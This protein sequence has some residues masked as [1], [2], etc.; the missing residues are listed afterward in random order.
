MVE[1]LRL[2][3]M[4]VVTDVLTDVYSEETKRPQPLLV[5]VMVE[6]ESLATLYSNNTVWR[7]RG[8]YGHQARYN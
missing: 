8:L 2:E 4:D 3:V 6:M 1:G 5:S 7:F